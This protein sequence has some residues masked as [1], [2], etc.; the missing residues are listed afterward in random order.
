MTTDH[1]FCCATCDHLI[2][3]RPIFH[4]GLTFC[5]AGCAADGPCM[6]SYDEAA[7]DPPAIALVDEAGETLVEPVGGRVFIEPAV[8]E[9]A[10]AAVRDDAIRLVRSTR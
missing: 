5:C 4:V 10:V 2:A 8:C 1:T 6:C 9:P 3:G 7:D